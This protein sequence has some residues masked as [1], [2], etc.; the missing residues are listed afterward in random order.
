M[1]GREATGWQ[2]TIRVFHGTLWP[3]DVWTPPH[4]SR[5]LVTSWDNCFVTFWLLCCPSPFVG[6]AMPADVCCEILGWKIR[7]QIWLGEGSTVQW[8][9]SP[10]APGSLKALLFAPILNKVQNKGT[11]GVPVRHGEEL[12]PFISMVRYPGRPVILGMEK[13]VKLRV[14]KSGE[15]LEADFSTCLQST[16][17]FG[18]NFGENIGENIGNFVSEFAFFFGNFVQQKCGVDLLAYNE[19]IGSEKSAQSFSARNFLATP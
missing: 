16:W 12:P 13:W 2:N 14:S 17:I 15:I 8:K 1:S 10:P 19:T 7:H 6:V 18:K 9:W 3:M 4:F 5:F 11:R